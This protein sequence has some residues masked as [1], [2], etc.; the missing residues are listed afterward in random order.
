MK[1]INLGADLESVVEQDFKSLH[2]GGGRS[3]IQGGQNAADQALNELNMVAITSCSIG[4]I[5]QRLAWQIQV[6]ECLYEE[7]F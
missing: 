5:L 2:S 6:I 7:A 4:A 3:S 1:I